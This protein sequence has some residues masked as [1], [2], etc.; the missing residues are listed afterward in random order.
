LLNITRKELVESLEAK[1]CVITYT[2]LNSTRKTIEATLRSDI[3][4]EL[5][6]RPEGFDDNREAA[7]FD[8]HCVNVLDIK[9]NQW[10]TIPV[11]SI[12]LFSA[13]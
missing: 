5:D 9:S 12:S 8:L 3:I 1:V 2:P 7:L 11:S 10:L 13:P 6:N 4:A